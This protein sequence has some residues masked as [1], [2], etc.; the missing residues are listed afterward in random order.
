MDLTT[1]VLFAGLFTSR[2][3]VAPAP[4]VID[5][6][7]DPDQITAAVA[8]AARNADW[9]VEYSGPRSL[10]ATHRLNQ[11]SAV[12]ALRIDQGAVYVQYEDSANLQY[13]ETDTG[14][15][16]HKLY[17][18]WTNLLTRAIRSELAALCPDL[19]SLRNPGYVG[20]TP[21]DL[22]QEPLLRGKSGR[23]L[24]VKSS[25]GLATGYYVR[26][27]SGFLSGE[28]QA[29]APV[30][31]IFYKEKLTSVVGTSMETAALQA[32]SDLLGYFVKSGG[33]SFSDAE[34]E[35]MS[36]KIDTIM[37][38]DAPRRDELL[39]FVEWQAQ[40]LDRKETSDKEYEFLLAQKEAEVRERQGT[41]DQKERELRLMRMQSQMQVA[42]L[43]TQQQQLQTQRGMALS[44]ALQNVNRS[45]VY[46][47]PV[48]LSTTCVSRPSFGTVTT[49]CN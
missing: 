37:M 40:K 27:F 17:F 44:Q 36:L 7:R 28:L 22:K 20:K 23:D 31:F 45:A 13:R 46:V 39:R 26:E 41:I 5:S 35:R 30:S 18:E 38:L 33:I 34:M 25:S 2:Q 47:P 49:T 42:S 29:C 9:A 1:F 21:S 24:I 10:K 43:A 19:T 11:Y 14:P 48:R 16:I 32:Y 8:D 4:I 6:S 12:V 3:L 15:E